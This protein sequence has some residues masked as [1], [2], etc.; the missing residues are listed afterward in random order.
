MTVEIRQ[1]LHQY[2]DAADDKN[3]EAIYMVLQGNMQQQKFSPEDLK[4]FYDRR[5]EYLAG[6]TETFTV[7]EAHKIIRQSRKNNEA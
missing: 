4:K 5:A 6:N 1:Q 3:I 2:I 7:E